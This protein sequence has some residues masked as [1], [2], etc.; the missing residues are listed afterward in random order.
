MLI[1]LLV[2]GALFLTWSFFYYLTQWTLV[3]LKVK[4]EK[5]IYIKV[6]SATALSFIVFSILLPM[7]VMYIIG[8]EKSRKFTRERWCEMPAKRYE[9]RKNLV[10]SKLL[11]QKSKGNIKMLLDDPTSENDSLQQWVYDLGM[12]SAGLGFQFNTLILKF[13]NDTV[14]QADIAEYID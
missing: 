1:Y 13:R 11:M 5:R 10:K 3:K 7:I 4:Q 9:T 2:V 8:Y 12:S 6:L 14:V